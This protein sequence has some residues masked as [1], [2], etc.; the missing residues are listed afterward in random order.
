MTVMQI[1]LLLFGGMSFLDAVNTAMATAGTGGFG[2]RND[3]LSGYSPYIQWVVTIFM[4]LFG[5]NFNAYYLIV[6][7]QIK[8]AVRMEEVRCYLGIIIVSTAIIFA[9]IYRSL[10]AVERTLRTAM[11]QVASIITTT[12]F[13]SVDY[14]LWPSLSKTVIVLIMFIGA[15]A[16]STGGGIK[17]SRFIILVKTIIKDAGALLKDNQ[18]AKSQ[19]MN[20]ALSDVMTKYNK[21]YGLDLHVDFNS[22]SK[23]L[24][25]CADTKKQKILQLY[26]SKIFRGIRPLILLNMIS[27]LTL[28]LDVL[29]SPDKLLNPNEL[30]L[31]DL[32]L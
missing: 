21:E 1:I 28:S 30:S 32:F 31:T 7:R 15:C 6:L 14:D 16:G 27:K 25:A 29:L 26:V 23:T 4:I 2:V 9:N 13:S 8:K 19:Q 18:E 17:V 12:G 10:G 20:L 5:V 3:S 24:V 22:L 11:F